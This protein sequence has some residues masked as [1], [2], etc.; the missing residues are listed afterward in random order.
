[1]PADPV[2]GSPGARQPAE[3]STTAAGGLVDS[4]RSVSVEDGLARIPKA[5]AGTIGASGAEAG[6]ASDAPEFGSTEPVAPEELMAPPEASQGMV[7]PAVEPQSPS[8]VPPAAA[9]EEDVVEE[10]VRAEPRT[11]SIRIFRKRGDE[12]VVVEEEDTPPRR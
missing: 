1:M 9:E 3:E 10:I 4:K 5:T 12:V 2:S 6:V 8:V 11:Q 7:G